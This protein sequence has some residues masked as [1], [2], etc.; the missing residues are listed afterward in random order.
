MNNSL[1][2][3]ELQ[4]AEARLIVAHVAVR[5][6]VI[7]AP[8]RRLAV[9]TSHPATS[10]AARR[11]PLLNHLVKLVTT[12]PS[13]RQRHHRRHLTNIAALTRQSVIAATAP[14]PPW[15]QTC[16][17]AAE[18]WTYES[19]TEIWICVIAAEIATVLP[20][21][22]TLAAVHDAED[23]FLSVQV[24]HIYVC[25]YIYACRPWQFVCFSHMMR[26]FVDDKS[27]SIECCGGKNV[28][29]WIMVVA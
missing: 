3:S 25:M 27:R 11:R 18:T 15:T 12:M 19:A 13:H 1:C 4:L 16:E 29:S 24:L 7:A 14:A 9:V 8:T 5:E 2:L 21:E 6:S 26:C 22:T 17:S 23:D 10:T 28:S 20:T